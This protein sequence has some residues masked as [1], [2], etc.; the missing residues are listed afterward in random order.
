MT[1][2][3]TSLNIDKVKKGSMPV[4]NTERVQ[5]MKTLT[6]NK[7]K[8]YVPRQPMSALMS[9]KSVDSSIPNKANKSPVRDNYRTEVN[10]SRRQ[11]N[12]QGRSYITNNSPKNA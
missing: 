3:L 2:K 8:A 7:P 1:A 12:L 10:R 4:M 5:P 11:G 9:K 6:S